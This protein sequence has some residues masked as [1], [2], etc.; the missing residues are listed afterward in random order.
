MISLRGIR[1]RGGGVPTPFSPALAKPAPLAWSDSDLS[2]LLDGSGIPVVANGG[3]IH[4]WKDAR[5]TTLYVQGTGATQPKLDTGVLLN[6]HR[7]LAFTAAAQSEMDTTSVGVSGNVDWSYGVVFALDST[8]TYAVNDGPFGVIG[9][10]SSSLCFMGTNAGA[11]WSFSAAAQVASSVPHPHD[12]ADQDFFAHLGWV[13]HRASD[14]R[15][16]VLIDG[17]VVVS[18]TQSFSVLKR[19][20][21]GA[22]TAFGLKADSHYWATV[23]HDVVSDT[24][25][26][27]YEAYFAARYKLF[28]CFGLGD[29]LCFGF[30]DGGPGSNDYLAFLVPTLRTLGCSRYNFGVTGERTDQI[31]LRVTSITNLTSGVPSVT[32]LNGGTNDVFQLGTNGVP[33][34]PTAAAAQALANLQACAAAIHASGPNKVVALAMPPV[35]PSASGRPAGLDTFRNALNAGLSTATWADGYVPIPALLTDATNTTYYQADQIHMTA[36]GRQTWAN[37]MTAPVKAVLGLP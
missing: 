4:D 9:G 18:A 7:S 32:T 15:T 11:G 14:N 33:S 37:A 10:P 35:G 25:R 23:M 12:A 26:A 28:T 27:Q 16:R 8:N 17:R 1:L 31:L 21:V 22:G 20:A 19:I 36:T 30:P 29:S 13:D 5:G 3:S 34:D 2:A 6:G 24:L